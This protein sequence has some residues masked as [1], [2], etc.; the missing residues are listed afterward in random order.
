MLIHNLDLFSFQTTHGGVYDP[1]QYMP[2][3]RVRELYEA[4]SRISGN[5]W[6][7]RYIPLYGY[8]VEDLR[9]TWILGVRRWFGWNPVEDHFQG[10]KPRHTPWTGEFER[11]K[12]QNPKGI[13]VEMEPD[14]VR[15][16]E[17]LLEF[18]RQRE[19]P[20]LLVYSPEYLGMQEMTI[21]R[22]EIF[23]RFKELGERVRAPVWDFSGSPVSSQRD[24]FYNSQH[25]NAGGAALFSVALAERLARDTTLAGAAPGPAV[26]GAAP[27]VSISAG[28]PVGR[29]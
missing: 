12:A 7:S 19:I 4:L 8:A 9:L 15:E 5:S 6:K 1:G 3:L 20:V 16:M 14:G 29:R 28:S 17:G 11:F 26:A 21:N 22:A 23:A 27:T 18:C 24:K 2:Y 10:F 25:L 13:R